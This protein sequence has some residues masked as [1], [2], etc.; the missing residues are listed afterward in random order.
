LF[1]PRIRGS[2][3]CGLLAIHSDINKQPLEILLVV[4]R[5]AQVFAQPLVVVVIGE[6]EELL[7]A[8]DLRRPQIHVRGNETPSETARLEHVAQELKYETEALKNRAVRHL[9]L[10]AFCHIV[11]ETAFDLGEPLISRRVHFVDEK[12]ILTVVEYEQLG[13]QVDFGLESVK[14]VDD[15]LFIHCFK[16]PFFFDFLIN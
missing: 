2:S 16:M 1:Y 14:V 8:S 15:S 3:A 6:L 10:L 4:N 7:E 5:I 11:L 9:V 13:E 12:M